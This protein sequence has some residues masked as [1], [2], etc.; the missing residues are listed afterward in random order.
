MLNIALLGAGRIGQ[1][2]AKSI[3]ANL[4][5]SPTS[6]ATQPRSWLCNTGASALRR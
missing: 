6:S 5:R 3:S 1:V 2:H 4:L